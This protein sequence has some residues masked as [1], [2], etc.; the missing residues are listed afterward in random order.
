MSGVKDI[1]VSH[2]DGKK[3]PIYDLYTSKIIEWKTPDDLTLGSYIFWECLHRVVTT[4]LEEVS[5][6]TLIVATEPGKA[7]SVT[8]ARAYLKVV[9]DVLNHICSYPLTKLDSSA[10]G[11][12]R[13]NHGWETFKSIFRKD[14]ADLFFKTTQR[15]NLEKP[16]P[17]GNGVELTRHYVDLFASFTDYSSATDMFHH[18]VGKVLA[19]AWLERCG[20]P[21]MLGGILMATGYR[22]RKIYFTGTGPL[23]KIGVSDPTDKNQDRR[24]IMLRRGILMGDPLTKPVLHLLNA[25]IRQLAKRGHMPDFY[26]NVIANKLEVA[27]I[28]SQLYSTS[29]EMKDSP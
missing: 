19:K 9:L 1:I 21:P 2:G 7:R 16:T 29:R 26:N 28:F 5:V 11:M 12:S 25:S 3:V 10:A 15:N 13:S 8:K 20:V 6:A 18:D 4:P 17:D 22:P 23:E 14:D 27:E 24:H